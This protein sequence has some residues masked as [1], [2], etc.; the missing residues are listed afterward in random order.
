M[1]SAN[2]LRELDL[3]REEG[4]FSVDEVNVALDK[5]ASTI[6]AYENENKEL[7]RKMEFL[8]GKIEEYREEEDSIKTALLT[9]QKMADKIKKESKLEAENL[10]TNSETTAKTTIMEANAK[11]EKI[12]SEAREYSA[13]LIKGKTEEANAIVE[14]AQQKANEAISSANIVAQDILDQAKQ[15]SAELISKSKEE[16]EAYEKLTVSLKRD[17]DAFI[18]NLKQLYSD[19]LEAVG[20]VDLE[21]F[22]PDEE[23]ISSIHKEV[24]NLVNEIEE[25]REAI[26]QE[27]TIDKVDAEEEEVNVIDDEPAEDEAD[28]ADD[29]T[30]IHDDDE[31]EEDEEE[32]DEEEDEEEYEDIEVIP[33]EPADP[34][35][36]VEAF[37]QNEYTP[38]DTSR[39]MVPEIDEDPEMEKSLFDEDKPDFENY[40]KVNKKDAHYDKTQTISLVPPEDFEEEDDDQP[41]FRG[42]F[43]RKR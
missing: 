33:E 25:I 31:E 18:A 6:E 16:K 14:D 26:P 11:A 34:M 2:D 17:A 19:Q 13:E 22:K 9:A 10:L 42:F 12:V 32:E 29:F 23:E 41:K 7:Y 28:E 39:R 35:A 3:S 21:S 24:D 1:I 43:K 15:T 37:S 30:I 20:N 36:A 4:G 8:A 38:V 40:F 27:I 5:A